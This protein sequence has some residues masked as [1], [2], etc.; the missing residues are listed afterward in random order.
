MAELGGTP[1]VTPWEPEPEPTHDNEG[2]HG[3]EAVEEEDD[4][5]E[6]VCVC[7]HMDTSHDE[8]EGMCFRGGCL[9]T[10]FRL[11]ERV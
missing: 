5:Y 11:G 7:E 4:F 10:R 9:C 6:H 3:F 2:Y 8:R 1:R